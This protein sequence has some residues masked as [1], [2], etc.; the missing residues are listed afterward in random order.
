MGGNVFKNSEPFDHSKVELIKNTI[1]PVLDK[2]RVAAFPIGSTADPKPGHISGDYD[3]LV[4]ER[5]L[6]TALGETDTKKL[7]KLLKNKFIEAGLRATINSGVHVLVP[8]GEHNYQVDIFVVE[9]A[10][11]VSKFHLHKIPEGSPYKGMNKHLVM[12]YLA[13]KQGLLWSPFKGLYR[14]DADGKRGELISMN[15]EQVS[16]VLLGANSTVASMDCVESMLAA[17]PN[18]EADAMMADLVEDPSWKEFR[19]E[20][21]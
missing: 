1:Y 7:K 15:I 6:A 17:L 14:R 4:D 16:Y 3:I 10:R 19:H 21:A 9:Y 5:P 2:L 12:M 18:D 8:D 11:Q 13:K 20:V